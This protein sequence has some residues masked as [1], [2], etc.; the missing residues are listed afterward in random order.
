M[1]IQIIIFSFNRA[2]QLDA[3]LNSIEKFIGKDLCDRISVI[4]NT[5]SVDFE[6]G[7]SILKERYD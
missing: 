3:L 1:K 2:M 4:Y 7:Y 5:S 6:R